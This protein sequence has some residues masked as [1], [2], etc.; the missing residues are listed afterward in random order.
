MS[1]KS[2]SMYVVV[3]ASLALGLAPDLAYARHH[4][5]PVRHYRACHRRTNGT[6]GAVAGGVGGGVIGSAITHGSVI[7]TLAGAA[8]GALAGH[9]LG[10]HAC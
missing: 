9:S 3:M 7:G 6:I 2:V 10:K 5:H 8:G 4:H 1:L